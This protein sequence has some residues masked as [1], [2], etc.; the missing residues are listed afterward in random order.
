[1]K[2]VL[3]ND[4]KVNL[5][6]RK[7]GPALISEKPL[8]QEKSG[9]V[10]SE[11]FAVESALYFV[12]GLLDGFQS[13]DVE[14]ECAIVKSYASKQ[15][16]KATLE[17]LNFAGQSCLDSGSDTQRLLASAMDLQTHT[18]SL[19]ALRLYIG[20]MGLQFAGVS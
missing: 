6:R 5:G 18:E 15:A 16:L 9:K 11:I 7:L 20:L 13:P 12:M 2:N 17:N 8:Y 19:D 10:C 1:M 14:L 4:A 3:R